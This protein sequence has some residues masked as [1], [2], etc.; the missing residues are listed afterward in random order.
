MPRF[1]RK[2]VYLLACLVL[3]V[4]ALTGFLAERPLRARAIDGVERSLTERA[5][6]ASELVSSIPLEIAKRSELDALVDRAAIAA[7]ARVTLITRD[8]VVVG[9]SEVATS[10]LGDVENHAARPE[11][12]AA[13]RGEIGR[14]TRR[15]VTV[16]REFLYVGV[17]AAS[18][19][20]GIVRLAVDLD[21]IQTAQAE[22]RGILFLAALLGIAA[23]IVFAMILARQMV[24]P[25]SELHDVV[26]GI[27]EGNLDRRLNW[28]SND[29]IGELGRAIND[30]AEA[31][32]DRLDDTTREN[33]RLE[34]VV[35]SMVEGVLVLDVDGRVTLANPRFQEL[36]DVWGDTLGRPWFELIRDPEAE[37]RV[38]KAMEQRELVACELHVRGKEERILQLHAVGFPAEGA[39]VGTVVVLHDISEIRRLDQV[40][41]DFIANASHELKTPLTAIRGFSDTLLASQV[42]DE[43]SERQVAIIE[44]NA[45]RMES[46]VNDLLT[47]SRIE[48]RFVKIESIAIDV[49]DVVET[50]LADLAPRLES[51]D[52][53][54]RLY[55][56]NFEEVHADPRALEQVLVNLLDNAL[57]YS[58]AGGRIG[59][60]AEDRDT[61]LAII[62]SDTGMGIPPDDLGR[63]FERFYRLDAARSRAL[64]GTGLGLSIVKHLVQSM[65]GEIRVESQLGHGSRFIFTLPKR[66]V[67]P[68]ET[69]GPLFDV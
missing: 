64:G 10:A 34:A 67:A 13:L 68:G 46:L 8:G 23:A 58:D 49:A 24:R 7:N 35:G 37:D 44:R 41:R 57:R 51:A 31:M 15:S 16:K 63:I 30:V 32:R 60:S 47:L 29:E 42:L 55:P 3:V 66:P 59:V 20:G 40:R 19:G 33:E 65:G 12:Q 6:L 45:L 36:L 54:A 4:I 53:V 56:E 52:V 22:L 39:R 26:V 69:L 18:P 1:Q 43:E 2:L 14:S 11:V 5:Q 50:I 9:D 38:R 48:G 28:W 25:V 62:V 21:E 17:P 61:H 27:A